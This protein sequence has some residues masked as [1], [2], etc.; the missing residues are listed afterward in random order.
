MS[1]HHSD[2]TGSGYGASHPWERKET[3]LRST[4]Y[5]CRDCGAVFWHSYPRT[6]SIFR[7]IYDAGLPDECPGLSKAKGA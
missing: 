7:S 6:P 1:E 3:R 2:I 5:E 4:K